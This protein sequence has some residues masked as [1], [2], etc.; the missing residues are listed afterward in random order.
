MSPRS[1]IPSPPSA[2]LGKI[3]TLL[4][5][6]FWLQIASGHAG[7]KV[8]VALYLADN[9]P[10]PPGAHLAPEKL[11]RNLHEVFGFTTYRLLKGE[12][13]VLSNNWEQWV[14]PRNDFFIRVEPLRRAS[15]EPKVVSYEIYKDGFIIARGKYEPNEGT[16]LFIDGPDFNKGRL[17]FVLEPR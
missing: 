12:N 4:L 17:I 3:L 13:I 2:R 10:P 16:P 15:G 9:A 6:I 14:V 1:R 11:S 7:D 5:G 8:W